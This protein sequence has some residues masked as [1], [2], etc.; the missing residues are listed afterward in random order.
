M[1]PGHAE[2]GGHG[3]CREQ[4]EVIP[5]MCPTRDRLANPAR[6]LVPASV[7]VKASRGR[8]T[9]EHV[10]DLLDAGAHLAGTSS[11]MRIG[12]EA[13]VAEAQLGRHGIEGSGAL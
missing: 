12:Q 13:L 11:G 3:R 10:L 1:S 5:A 7:G 2:F 4:V 6:A 8:F 9:L